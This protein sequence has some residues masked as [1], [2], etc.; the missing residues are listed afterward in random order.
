MVQETLDL[1]HQQP[2]Y[3]CGRLLAVLDEAQRRASRGRVT[4]TLTDRFYGAA[5]SA[6]ASAFTPLLKLAKTAHLPK[7]RK[8]QYAVHQE[9]DQL[10]AEVM[11]KL[12]RS[13]GF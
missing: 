13:G 4:A 1:Q 10:I 11:V 9:I 12:D 3:L 8:Q 6:P 7:L 5:S 2:A